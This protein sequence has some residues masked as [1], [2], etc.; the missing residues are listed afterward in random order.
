MS[1]L[2]RRAGQ[3]T[4]RV[5][6]PALIAL[7]FLGAM[8][9]RA[10]AAGTS[11]LPILDDS[12]Q[13]ISYPTSQDYGALIRQEGL[14]ASRPLAAIMDLFVVGQM[15]GALI[16][17]VLLLSALHGLSGVLFWRLFEK[18]FGTGT[19]F[20]VLYALLPLGVEGT[21]WLSASSRIVPGLLFTALAATVLDDYLAQGG[22]WRVALYAPLMLLSYGFYE[23]ILVLSVTLA[24]LQF[25][26]SVR[27]TRRAWAALWA[28]PM[29]AVYFTF[30]GLF[31][32]AAGAISARMELALPTSAWYFDSFLPEIVRQI[33]A[34]FLKGGARTL[35]FGF[36]RGL[37]GSLSVGGIVYLLLA[38]GAGAGL[39][40][41]TRPT[42]TRRVT[43]LSGWSG[44]LVWGV[45][46]GL[47]PVTPYFVIAN[48]YFSLRA[49]VASFVGAGLLVDLALRAVLRRGT[50]YAAVCGGL[51]TVCLVAGASEVRDFQTGARADEALAQAIL[52]RADEMSGRVGIL[53]IE[54]FATAEQNYAYHEHVASAGASEWAL[55]GKLVAVSGGELDFSP[56]PLATGGF[57][58]YHGW[59]TQTK[60][61]SGF[62]E[63]WAWDTGTQT[64]EELTAVPRAGGGEHDFDLY[65]A[66]GTP[67]GAVW[68]ED[69]YGYVKI[70]E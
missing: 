23:Q 67:W 1:T 66:D 41:L 17:P 55:Y 48:P 27:K 24:A 65:R 37:T 13:Y 50:A 68:E 61:L 49:T 26:S 39:F 52:T 18:R 57:S 12:I 4:P 6:R 70:F 56:V 53:G 47:A 28:L 29:A 45:L 8:L 58:F 64:L 63:I 38:A 22:G 21:Y 60:R 5:P 10:L 46:L 2:P 16:V 51:M 31:S 43:R 69:G 44:A 42:G 14:F 19:V 34:A 9:L 25:L 32:T 62:D 40:F 33:G 7:L 35:L 59:N 3:T 15:R 30:T 36:W 20:A 54:E 11:Y